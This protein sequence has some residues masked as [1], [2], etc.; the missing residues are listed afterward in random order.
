MK[1]SVGRTLRRFGFRQTLRGALIVGII[2]GVLMGVQGAAYAAAFPD[3]ASRAK[4]VASLDAMPAFNFLSGEIENAAQPDSYAIYKALPGMMLVTSIWGLMVATRLLRGDEEEGRTELLVS[5]ATTRR[6]ASLQLLIG[7]GYSLLAAMV[8]TAACLA[9]FDLSPSVKLSLG[10]SVLTTL[11]C[12]LPGIVFAAIGAFTSQLALTRG[13]AVLYGLAPLL[14]CFVVRGVGN[15]TSEYDWMKTVSLFGWS[16]RL[17]PVL[18]PHIAWLIPPVVLI[19]IFTA[20][21]VWLV[22]RRDYAA[23]VVYQSEVT[24]SHAALLGSPLAFAIR[25]NIWMFIWWLVGTV[26]F[27]A[28]MAAVAGKV[29]DIAGDSSAAP[30]VLAHIAPGE[31]K[32][33][34]LGFDTLILT[35]IMVALTIIMVAAFRRDEAHGYLDNFL[36]RPTRRVTWLI[37]RLGLI[38]VTS[39]VIA[40]AA[41]LVMRWVA[42]L[43]AIDVQLTTMLE[44]IISLVAIVLV[45]LGVGTLLYGVWPRLAVG[46]MVVVVG[47]AFI[48][49]I[50]KD[51]FHLA[52]WVEKTSLL[53][54]VPTLPTKSPDWPQVIWL[55]VIGLVLLACGIIAFMRRD[56]VAE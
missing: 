35:L 46:G 10:D 9:L 51:V 19:V 27:T 25:Q 54:Y 40:L 15:T 53:S 55:F 36:V 32:I 12:F 37:G 26:V 8:V 39:I 49:S 11:A 38:V 7:F 29:A 31:I 44:G 13:K 6:Y 50:L 18:A 24:R 33:A 41:T 5:G 3:I 17:N 4:L 34:F 14:I 16:D 28:F 42:S 30:S 2:G 20:L 21:A 52:D 1:R 45:T 48:E 43:L 47:W 56:I 23:S 22:A